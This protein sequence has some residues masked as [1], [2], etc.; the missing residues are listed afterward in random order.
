VKVT[1]RERYRECN[2]A[3]MKIR[4]LVG[5]LELAADYIAELGSPNIAEVIRKAIARATK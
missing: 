1:Y 4:L 2:P 3:A 5:L